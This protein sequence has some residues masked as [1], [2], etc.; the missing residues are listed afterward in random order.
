MD[1]ISLATGSL[2]LSASGSL[3]PDAVW[4]RYTQPV[5]WPVW[6]PHLREVEC[7]DAVIRPGTT[8]RVAGVGGLV[9]VFHID[10]V[11]HE[12]R[13]WSWSV[14]CGPLRLSFDHGVDLPQARSRH[15]LG[16]TAWLVTH[17]LW[18][19]AVGYAPMARWSLQRLVTG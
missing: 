16:S 19:L 10:A 18:P 17:A 7:P 3:A 11:D 8:G 1:P 14:R 15:P 2:R 12:A 13:T 5:W 4:E 9:A 6:A